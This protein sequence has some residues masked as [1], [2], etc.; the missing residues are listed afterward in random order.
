MVE[1]QAVVWSNV[2][3]V[4]C[5]VDV[6]GIALLAVVQHHADVNRTTH[7][8]IAWRE[9]HGHGG[10]L[11]AATL[12]G[13]SGERQDTEQQQTEEG[14]RSCFTLHALPWSFKALEPISKLPPQSALLLVVHCKPTGPLGT[15][16]QP[17]C[18]G[19]S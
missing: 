17:S 16:I 2:F 11:N 4:E 7:H 5:H 18:E 6:E 14:Q 1:K 9:G 3:F 19:E 15:L 8:R 13:V 10:G 12:F